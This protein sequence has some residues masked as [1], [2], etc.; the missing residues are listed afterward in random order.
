MLKLLVGGGR[1]VSALA[2]LSALAYA[3]SSVQLNKG[4]LLQSS[5]QVADAGEVISK[6]SYIPRRWI[7]TSVPSTVVA[8]QDAAGEFKSSGEIYAGMNLRKIPGMAYEIG[9][10][11]AH[12]PIPADSPYASS[13][14]YRTEFATPALARH[15]ALHFDGINNRANIWLNGRKIADA[16]DVAGAYRRYEFDIT[17]ELVRKGK[18]VLAV[19]V[20]AQT[21][22]DLGINWVDWN[23]TPPDKDMG[24]WQKVYLTTSG[25]VEICYPAVTTHLLHGSQSPAELSILAG[26]RNVSEK[27]VKGLFV[28]QI[29]GLALG[30]REPVT[31]AAGKSKSI[32]LTPEQ[33]PQLR[34]KN[35]QLWWPAQMGKPFLYT[36]RTSFVVGNT[37]SDS[38][39]TRVGLR[40]ITSEMAQGGARLFRVNG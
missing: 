29:D 35:A 34:V 6:S 15:V 24:L 31:L 14:W 11:F 9:Q 27:P 39:S 18:N 21:Q 10:Q 3:Q 8:A 40:E 13:W 12:K 20:F 16:R 5:R 1:C 4:W 32:T 33:F 23:P 38:K 30:V 22:N 17:Q 25:P 7:S 28:A 26:L 19:E 2:L 37:I 36:L